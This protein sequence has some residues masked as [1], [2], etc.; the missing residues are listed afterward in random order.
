M[1]EEETRETLTWSDCDTYETIKLVA[2][3]YNVTIQKLNPISNQKA[4]VT[5]IGKFYNISRLL[6]DIRCLGRPEPFI[7]LCPPARSEYLP[8]LKHELKLVNVIFN[9]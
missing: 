6:C 1:L 2:K 9:P 3:N 4:E 5:I 8:W 7:T